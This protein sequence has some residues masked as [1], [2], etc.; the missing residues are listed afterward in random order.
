MGQNAMTDEDKERRRGALLDAAQRLFRE[1]GDLPPVAEIARAASLAKGTVYLYFTSKEE[2]FVALL[3]GCYRRLFEALAVIV[4]QLPGAPKEA[5]R[6]FAQAY[7]ATILCQ[8]DFLPLASLAN[9]VL[10]QNLPVEAMRRFKTLL[11]MGLAM[12]GTKLEA[13]FPDLEPGQGATL[14]MQTYA[15]T[16][17]LWQA[18]DYPEAARQLLTEPALK[19]LDRRFATEL[20]TSVRAQW[21]G[22]LADKG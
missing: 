11:A 13:I 14:L 21:L 6:Q 1:R 10:E 16:L 18:L 5:A 19:P 3:E 2:I 22:M 20:E 9:S 15:L 12:A 17:G 7:T 8:D 4:A